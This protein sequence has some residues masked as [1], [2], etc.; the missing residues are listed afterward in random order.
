MSKAFFVTGTDTDAGKT[1]ACRALLQQARSQGFRTLAMKPIASGC[2]VTPQGLRNADAL[3]LQQAITEPLEYELLNPFAYVPAIAPHIAAGLAGRQIQTQCLHDNLVKL[4][5]RGDLV[6]IEGAGGWRLPISEELYLSDWVADERLPVILVVGAKL[7]CINHAILTYEAIRRDGL[8]VAGW[9]MNRIDPGMRH[10]RE[11]LD[12]LKRRLPV[13]LLG[14]LPWLG[15][16]VDSRHL[17]G[18]LDLRPL[19]QSSFSQMRM[20]TNIF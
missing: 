20:N 14:E 3:A 18:Y 16:G 6:L 9:I 19:F 8:E 7:G 12:S 13:P 17:E 10:Y 11:N 15:D 1:F 5:E 2:S 4:R